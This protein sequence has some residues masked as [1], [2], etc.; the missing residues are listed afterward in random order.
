MQTKPL[1]LSIL[2]AALLSAGALPIHAADGHFYDPRN[3]ASPTDKTIGYELFRTIGCPGRG[4]LDTPCPVSKDPDNDGDGVVDS[5]D[6]CPDTPKGRKVDANG[7]EFDRDGDGIV[8][9]DDGCPDVAAHTPN[10]CPAPAVIEQVPP[11]A[12]Q[13]PVAPVSQAQPTQP[14]NN[15]LYGSGTS[16]DPVQVPRRL[17]LE[18]VNFDFDKASLR[19]E[20]RD[21]IDKNA[22]EL[23]E[24]G[25]I[26]VEVSGHTDNVGS[27]RYNMGLSLRRAETVRSYL[28]SKGISS[29]RLI[30]K[31]Y[32]ESQPLVTNDTDDS[33]FQNRRVELNQIKE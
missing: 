8:D 26:K 30:A 4:L 5:K 2:G 15:A 27:D 12:P 33:R 6:Q 20:D 28:I 24:W 13:T 1:V 7:C 3:A 17:V 19:Q 14:S 22:A 31:G 10:G 16:T 32:G 9:D 21:V 18:G 25:D 11:P 29:D 23:K